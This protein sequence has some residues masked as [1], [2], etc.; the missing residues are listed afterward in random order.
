[1]G[2][3]SQSTL[4]SRKTTHGSQGVNSSI[5]VTGI[6]KDEVTKVVWLDREAPKDLVYQFA[7]SLARVYTC[8]LRKAYRKVLNDT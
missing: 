4:N 1:V 3:A 8:E 2:G 6:V 7:Y 5:V